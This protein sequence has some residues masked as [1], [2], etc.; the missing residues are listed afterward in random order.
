MIINKKQTTSR[1]KTKINNNNNEN[2]AINCGARDFDFSKFSQK[3]SCQVF[4]LKREG[5]ILIYPF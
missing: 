2:Q 4:P 5:L 1:I 3:G